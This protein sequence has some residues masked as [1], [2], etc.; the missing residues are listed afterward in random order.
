[1]GNE[2]AKTRPSFVTPEM[3][4]GERDVVESIVNRTGDRMVLLPFKY[5]VSYLEMNGESPISVVEIKI[6]DIESDKYPDYSIS[7]HKCIAA[8]TMADAL[9]VPFELYVK[10]SNG[11][12]GRKRIQWDHLRTIRVPEKSNNERGDIE[13]LVKFATDSFQWL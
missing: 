5:G 8:L 7:I 10:Y 2:N 3:I 1:M 11:K 4:A 9:G 6:R 13:P 12:T